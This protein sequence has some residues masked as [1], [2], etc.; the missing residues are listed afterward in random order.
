M[1]KGELSF[2][3]IVSAIIAVLILV[4]LAI[5]FNKQLV[6]LLSPIWDAIRS[7]GGIGEEIAVDSI[8]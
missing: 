1:K 7:V 3:V 8:K 2:E 5:I 4:I 6:E